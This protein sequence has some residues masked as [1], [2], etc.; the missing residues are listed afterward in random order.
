MASGF[1]DRKSARSKV[2]LEGFYSF[3]N[4]CIPCTLQDI[5]VEGAG[6]K[7]NQIL[8]PGDSIRLKILFRNEERTFEA[9]VVNVN[10]TRIGVSFAV[11]PLM[12]D[13]LKSMILAYQR[14]PNFKRSS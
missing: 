14:P 1:K 6:L 3:S 7:I 10:G 4:Q 11:D 13:F 8:V 9:T 2:S 5:S 12:E